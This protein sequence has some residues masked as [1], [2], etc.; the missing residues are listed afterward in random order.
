MSSSQ[1]AS[2][3]SNG[4]Q[5]EMEM[6]LSLDRTNQDKVNSRPKNTKKAYDPKIKEYRNWC[7]T[8]FAHLPVEMRYI[9]TGE[10]AHFFL[11]DAVSFFFLFFY[12]TYQKTNTYFMVGCW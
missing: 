3:Y 8:K 4:V 6:R 5:T 9:V 11:D 2:N 7:D 1:S 12:C 10:K